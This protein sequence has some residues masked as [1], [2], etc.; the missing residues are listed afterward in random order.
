MG[1]SNNK[2]WFML[3]SQNERDLERIQVFPTLEKARQKMK[4]ELL[5]QLG[6]SFDGYDEDDDYGLY[7][8]SAWSNPRSNWDWTIIQLAVGKMMKIKA[9]FIREN[10]C[11]E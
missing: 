11:K 9:D 7:E 5:L 2:L 1:T 3:L 4:K 8:T 6:G 10:A